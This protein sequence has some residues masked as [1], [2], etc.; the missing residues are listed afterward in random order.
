MKIGRI[1]KYHNLEKVMRKSTKVARRPRKTGRGARVPWTSKD[2]AE[3][4]R[5]NRAGEHAKDIGKAMGRTEGAVRQKAFTNGVS[6][7]SRRGA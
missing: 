3:L 2:L 7:R 4:K 6:L 1:S 5:R